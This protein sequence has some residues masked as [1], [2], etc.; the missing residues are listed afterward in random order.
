MYS[1]L[2]RPMADIKTAVENKRWFQVI[3][4]DRETYLIIVNYLISHFEPESWILHISDSEMS[5]FTEQ[6]IRLTE[7]ILLDILDCQ[8]FFQA[9]NGKDFSLYS[10]ETCILKTIAHHKTLL[11]NPVFFHDCNELIEHEKSLPEKYFTDYQYCT[12]NALP[13]G[14]LVKDNDHFCDVLRKVSEC[15]D[16]FSIIG[17]NN[18]V[19]TKL[20]LW[21]ISVNPHMPISGYAE[22]KM[23]IISCHCCTESVDEL[24]DLED[25]E[26]MKIIIAKNSFPIAYTIPEENII[27]LDVWTL[28]VQYSLILDPMFG[29]E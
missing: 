2:L 25:L 28:L 22:Q 24:M 23:K 8:N 19:E 13:Y 26:M 7:D 16:T 17:D 20:A 29:V 4:Q 6:S 27:V 3:G 10:G 9:G 11:L 12:K 18:G 5:S 21:K 1:S 14:L 15:G